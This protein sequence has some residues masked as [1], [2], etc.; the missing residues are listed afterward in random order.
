MNYRVS[1]NQT[2]RFRVTLFER[3]VILLNTK[4]ALI[5]TGMI[6]CDLRGR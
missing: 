4:K 3:L 2:F 5:E 1:H 6:G